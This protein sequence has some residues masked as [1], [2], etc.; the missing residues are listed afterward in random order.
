MGGACQLTCSIHLIQA[1][2][3]ERE[4]GRRI[5]GGAWGEMGQP[6]KLGKFLRISPWVPIAYGWLLGGPLDFLREPHLL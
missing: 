3:K 2:E 5:E 1:W 6:N 4:G